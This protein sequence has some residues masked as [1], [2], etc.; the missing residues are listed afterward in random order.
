MSDRLTDADL[1]RIEAANRERRARREAATPGDHAPN[2]G[3]LHECD[4]ALL[5]AARTDDAAEVI[6]GLVAEVRRLLAAVARHHAQR[7]DDR[8]IEDDAALYAAAGLGPHDPRVGDKF[9]MLKNCAR[10]IDRRC[11]G[12]GW[13]SYAELEAE[14]DR[15]KEAIAASSA[16][17][18]EWY[19]TTIA[20]LEDRDRY[21]A[22]VA[23]L[24]AEVARLR[25][26]A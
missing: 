19:D 8:C 26:G 23:D 11:R 7:A 6:D 22:R 21:R 17:A 10:F 13:P 25:I 1:A 20:A 15:F 2:W 4:R 9:E 18:K 12:G 14:R 5:A 16:E 3:Y 24:E